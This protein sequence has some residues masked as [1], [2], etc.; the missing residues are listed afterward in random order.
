MKISEK[1]REGLNRSRWIEQKSIRVYEN[2]TK[3]L[4]LPEVE[5][6]GEGEGDV[7]SPSVSK[8]SRSKPIR[9]FIWAIALS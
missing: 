3:S 9:K 2:A 5:G 8:V 6:W 4:P 1:M 7:A